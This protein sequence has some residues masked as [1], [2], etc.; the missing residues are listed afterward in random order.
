MF[1]KITPEQAGIG[2]LNVAKYISILQKRGVNMHGLLMV[3]DGK[4]FCEEYWK[5]FHKDFH[6]RMYS[7]TKSFVGIG[8]CLLIQDGLLDLSDKIYKFF[9]D[10]I[11]NSLDKY[12]DVFNNLGLDVEIVDS[13]KNDRCCNNNEEKVIK[14]MRNL[15]LDNITPVKALNILFDMKELLSYE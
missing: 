13:I 4:I 9:P 15:N 6:H 10:K 1:E 12:M 5:P 8:I 11:D 3:K 7:Q 14:K 2:S